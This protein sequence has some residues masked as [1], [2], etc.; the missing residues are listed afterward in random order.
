MQM[1]SISSWKISSCCIA[2][3]LAILCASSAKAQDYIPL[4]INP[5]V[6]ANFSD[7]VIKDANTL[8]AASQ[9]GWNAGFD[10]RFG[11][12]LL[13][14]GG[15]HIYG[16]GSALEIQDSVSLRAQSLRSSQLKIP[17]GVGYKVFRLDYFN[18]WVYANGVLNLTMHSF[19]DDGWPTELAEVSQSSLGARFGLGFDISRFTVELNYEQGISDYISDALSARNRLVTLALGYK[20]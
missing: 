16:Q 12:K 18:V 10:F 6:G 14:M 9:L 7:L 8:R 17:F 19:H 3:S 4:V 2:F 20:L 13:L 15:I 11:T 1:F 5:K